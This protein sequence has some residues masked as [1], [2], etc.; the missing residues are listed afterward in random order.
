MGG[1]AR[2][3]DELK[4]FLF[5][6][7]WREEPVFRNGF[8]LPVFQGKIAQSLFAPLPEFLGSDHVGNA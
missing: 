4:S 5:K 8:N 6:S 3:F 7:V 2:S 1:M